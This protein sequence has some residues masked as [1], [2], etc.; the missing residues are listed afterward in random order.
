MGNTR[1]KFTLGSFC[2]LAS[3]LCSS[4]LSA[5]VADSTS[6]QQ[7]L[8]DNIAAHMGL[9]YVINNNISVE[10]CQQDTGSAQ[11]YQGQIQLTF[12]QDVALKDWQIYFS[13]TSNIKWDGS[14]LFDI[15]HTNGDIHVITPVSQNLIKKGSYAIDFKGIGS[16]VN[17]SEAFPNYFISAT[18]LQARV[19]QMTVPLVDSDTQLLVYPHVLPFVTPEQTKRRVGDKVPLATPEVMFEHYASINALAAESA[20]TAPRLI[21][22]TVSSQFDA[23]QRVSVSQGI[24]VDEASLSQFSAAFQRLAKKGLNTQSTGLPLKLQLNLQSGLSTQAYQLTISEKQIFIEASD[25]AGLF[26]GL[27]SLYQLLDGNNSLPVGNITDAPRYEFRGLHVDVARNFH[28]KAFIINLLEQMAALK[29][30][31]LHFHLAE[32]EAWRLE[33]P[34]LPELT[35]IGGFRCFDPLEQTCLMPQLGSGPERKTKVNGYL[36]TQDYIDILRFADA[37]FIEVIPSLDMPGHSRAAIKSMEARYKRLVSEEKTP[38]AEQYLLTEFADKSQYRSIQH[39]DDNTLNPCLD[40][41]YHFVDKVLSELIKMHNKAGV[42]LKRYHIGADETAGAW[43]GSPACQAMIAGNAR[44]QSSADLGPYFVERVAQMVAAKGIEAAAWD[45][46]LSHAKADQL[47]AKVQANIWGLLPSNG[48]D[49]AHDFVNRGWDTVLSFP[50]VLYF[51]FPYQADPKEPGYYW[52][53][54]SIDSFKVFQ[55]MP[56]NLP[57]HAEFWTDAIG[58]DYQSTEKVSLQNQA[59]VSGIQA[60]LWS[61]TVRSDDSANYM[62][63]PRLIAFAERA[64]FKPEWAVAYQAGQTYSRDSKLFTELK[65][66]QMYQDWAQFSQTMGSQILTDLARDEVLFRLPTP[67]AKIK[68]GW[69]HANSMFSGLTIE[70]QQEGEKQWQVYSQPVKVTKPVLLRSSMPGLLRYSRSVSVSMQQKVEE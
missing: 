33:I 24:A 30:N 25:N 55:F 32:D 28:S 4:G 27:M 58:N 6:A 23:T 29:I 68:Q 54:R 41:T 45:D 43:Q 19:I 16:L 42:A 60:Q 69:L 66:Q 5:A 46:G 50:D 56:D 1:R 22:H 59:K 13:N 57:A 14:E 10:N 21:P 44:L 39:Y 51:D 17:E 48:F 67:G 11:C 8:L 12:K 40:S 20:T 49:R 61:E 26:Y 31:K 38:E 52:G 2:G 36:T 7:Q 62:L 35:D 47:P 18:D 63:F 65:Q 64:W 9:T 53:M 34:G 15:Q 3:L 70:Y 37:H